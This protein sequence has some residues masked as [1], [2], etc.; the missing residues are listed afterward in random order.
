MTS[1]GRTNLDNHESTI[2]VMCMLSPNDMANSIVKADTTGRWRFSYSCHL[3]VVVGSSPRLRLSPDTGTTTAFIP[4][5]ARAMNEITNGRLT[6]PAIFRQAHEIL[7]DL[8]TVPMT[9]LHPKCQL[10]VP[11]D[12]IVSMGV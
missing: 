7:L 6:A 4:S 9:Y 5:E 11:D 2:R 1:C 12:L 10:Q 8:S 3:G